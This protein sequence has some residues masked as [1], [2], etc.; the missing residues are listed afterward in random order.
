MEFDDIKTRLK[1]LGYDA[2]TDDEWIIKFLINKIENYVKRTCNLGSIPNLLKQIL[3]D[4][5]CGEFFLNRKNTG[6]LDGFNL[7]TAIKSIQEGDTNITFSDGS[8]T[9]EQ[10]LHKLID[11]LMTGRKEDLK[12]IRCFKW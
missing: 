9:P 6:N 7:D 8:M 5:V 4:M 10:R 11:Y 3:I 12:S 2:V 1:S